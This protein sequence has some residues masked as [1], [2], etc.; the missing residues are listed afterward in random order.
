M[1]DEFLLLIF[2]HLKPEDGR[3]LFL[4]SDKPAVDEL[5][6]ALT[7]DGVDVPKEI[8]KLYEDDTKY[9]MEFLS[10]PEYDAVVENAP[11]NFRALFLENMERS[12]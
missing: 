8:T 3:F 2:A 5:Y 10:Y 11:P 4:N 9:K 6:N 12:D 1:N 7:A